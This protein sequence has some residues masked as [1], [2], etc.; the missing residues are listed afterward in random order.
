[1]FF[2]ISTNFLIAKLNEVSPMIPP[3]KGAR[4][5]FLIIQQKYFHMKGTMYLTKVTKASL[6]KFPL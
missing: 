2:L 1:M 3:L 4:G 5:M 6:F